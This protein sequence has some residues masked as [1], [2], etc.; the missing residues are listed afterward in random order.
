[1]ELKQFQHV[2]RIAGNIKKHCVNKIRP[3]VVYLE[4]NLRFGDME[5]RLASV[6]F[7]W[8]IS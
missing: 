1:M 7:R 4:R 6:R 5:R 3:V 8:V 2:G